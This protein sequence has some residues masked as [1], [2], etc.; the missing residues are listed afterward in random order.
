MSDVIQVQ[1]KFYI[2]ATASI[3]DLGSRVLK[4]GDTF[5]IF[6]RH[7]DIRPLGFENQGVFHEGTRFLSKWKLG[8][9]D[10]SPL[11]LSSNVK[12]DNDILAVDLTNPV[13]Q[14]N[15]APGLP[16]GIIHLVRTAFLWNGEYF[17]RIEVSSFA[18]EPVSLMLQLDFDAD[19]IDLFELRGTTRKRRGRLLEPEV[20]PTRVTLAY[21]GLDCVVRKTVFHFRQPAHD[22]S[23][24]RAVFHVDL[25][26]QEP[27]FLEFRAACLV[28]DQSHQ[29]E[30]FEGAFSKVHCA[31]KEYRKDI[32]LV[33]TSNALFNDWVHQSR[34]DLHMLLTSTPC[35]DYP[36]AGIPWF[37]AIFG[38][39]GIIAGLETLWTDPEI[40]RGVLSYLAANQAKESIA[41]R[42]AEPGKILHEERK[43]EMA[44]LKEIPFGCYY[45]S[46]DST[47]LWL[48]LAGSYYERTGDRAF[49]K[50]LWPN[51]QSALAWIDNYGD[52]DGD[53]F[54][55]YRQRAERGLNNQGWKDSQDA[56]FHAD[57]T[58]AP[59]PIALCE[60][61]GYV[62]EAKLKAAIL[63]ELLGH[64]DHADSL[65]HEAQILKTRFHDAFWC[66]QLKTYALALDG[67][68]R[69]CRVRS[70]NAG[71]CLFT[72][73][74]Q[75][76]AA[77]AI[78]TGLLTDRFFNGW[79]IRTIASSEERY[80]PMSYHNGSVWPHDNALIG[81]GFARYGF[82]N[83]ALRILTALFDASM[84]MD[85][86]R[87]PELYC[88]FT[89]RRGE[90]PTLYP[91]ACNPQCWSSAAVF[92]LVQACLGL[93]F[94]T[95]AER[96]FL[97][98]PQ[99]PECLDRLEITNL[100]V[101]GSV[102]DISVIRHAADVGV[103]VRHRT[104]K[105][106]VVVT[107]A[108]RNA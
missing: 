96:I 101:G 83:A 66:D 7:G 62:Y 77:V 65:R 57:G 17:E 104:G 87:L 48:I 35:G 76:D 49:V 6:D 44:A 69:P 28:G 74:A 97:D 61:Q 86:N 23:S 40:A 88:G 22:I 25:H 33:E 12:E 21:E 51:I 36:Y 8:L 34:A 39:D 103:N 4:Q 41:E 18:S 106:E 81:A 16:Q 47:P 15:G 37:S 63:A 26:K 75:P 82:K 93:R 70:S 20:T 107:H 9:N 11:L 50:D 2:R 29:A 98:N 90:G 80:N 38:R 58:L 30:S 92:Y 52:C 19:F 3:A 13:F 100:K 108:A 10:A 5:A 79:G 31:Y 72:G 73:I 64:R 89:R 94:E 85:L 14:A 24:G 43:G 59:A 95:S 42:D 71:Q 60:V 53:G 45:G 102:V 46:I 27:R 56:I 1:G 55:E 99:L 68:K 84:F 67:N 78:K 54:V 91:V 32:T 105:V